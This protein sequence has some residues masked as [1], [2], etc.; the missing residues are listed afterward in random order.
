MKIVETKSWV[1]VNFCLLQSRQVLAVKS[2]WSHQP[3]FTDVGSL[4]ST[5][6]FR[7]HAEWLA[8]RKCS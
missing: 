8:K 6:C 7:L 3:I 4:Q 2:I 1:Y 5:D